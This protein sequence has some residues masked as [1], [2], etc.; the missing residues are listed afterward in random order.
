MVQVK[1]IGI[2][3]VVIIFPS[4]IFLGTLQDQR[5]SDEWYITGYYTPLEKDFSGETVKVEI[6]GKTDEFKQDFLETIKIEGWGKTISGQYIGWYDSSFHFNDFPT[7]MHDNELIVMMV[8]ADPDVL[9]QGL[10]ISI[11]SLPSPWNTMEFMVSDVGPSIIGKHI[12]VYVGE[13][14]EARIETER[15]TGYENTVCV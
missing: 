15:I 6:N 3:A 5:C 13:G 4:I 1:I 10:S 11:T 7:D 12:D 9:E 14:E 2:A 8:A